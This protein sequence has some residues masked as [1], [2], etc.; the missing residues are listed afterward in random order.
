ALRGAAGL[1]RALEGPAQGADPRAYEPLPS[2]Q[3]TVHCL[4]GLKS[5]ALGDERASGL[6][7]A[8]APRPPRPAREG[9]VLLTPL[10]LQLQSKDNRLFHRPLL[11]K[12]VGDGW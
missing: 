12:S 8:A 10:P 1:R 4:L 5:G 9:N 2:L 3:G 7:V 6:R 11:E